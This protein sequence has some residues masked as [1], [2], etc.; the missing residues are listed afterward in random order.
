[1]VWVNPSGWLKERQALVFSDAPATTV[2]GLM[3]IRTKGD[4][5]VFIRWATASPGFDVMDVAIISGDGATGRLTSFVTGEYG[6]ALW[7]CE[8]SLGAFLV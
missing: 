6:T 5:V 2:Y 1:M 7:R 3:M 8:K 4:P